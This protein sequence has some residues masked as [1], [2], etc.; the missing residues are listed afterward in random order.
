MLTLTVVYPDSSANLT[1]DI[2]R[3]VSVDA[4]AYGGIK[5]VV[6]DNDCDEVSYHANAGQSIMLTN[7]A[8][9]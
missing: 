8:S 4:D 2:R 7:T 5:Y 9:K 6:I 1:V 3:V